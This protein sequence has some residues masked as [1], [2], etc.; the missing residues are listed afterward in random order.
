MPCEARLF[1]FESWMEAALGGGDWFAPLR[2]SA[3]LLDARNVIVLWNDFAGG[4]LTLLAAPDAP[5]DFIRICMTVPPGE[6]SGS[7][8]V[9]SIARAWWQRVRADGEIEGELTLFALADVAGDQSL[10][11]EI[12]AVAMRAVTARIKLNA[13][14]ATSALKTAAFDQL[15]FGMVIIDKHIRIAEKNEACRALFARSDG[16]GACQE[17][18]SCHEPADQSALMSA[19]ERALSG[20]LNAAVLKVHRAGG[21]QPY[22]VRVVAPRAGPRDHCLLMIVDPDD[23]PAAGSEIWRAMF[24]LTDCELIIAEGLVSGRRITEIANQR[25]VSIETVRSQTKRMFERLNVSSQAE[26]AARLSRSAP[27]KLASLT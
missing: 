16:L 21:A 7:V 25:G 27:F 23:E 1:A 15:P 13:V 20:D 8:Q 24:D 9:E 17:K 11:G 6:R 14:R 3:D 22:V 4:G 5:S 12:A 18:L 2:K 26:A 10:L 19:I